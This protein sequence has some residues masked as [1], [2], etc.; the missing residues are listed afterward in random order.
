MNIFQLIFNLF[1]KKETTA[2]TVS[3][4]MQTALTEW[5]DLY[6]MGGL[7]TRPEEESKSYSL[8]LPAGIASEFSRLLLSEADVHLMGGARASYLEVPL[9]AFWT[10]FSRQAEAA[11][12]LGSMVFKPYVSGDTI[13]VNLL[14]ADQYVPTA[15]DTTGVVT[16]AVFVDTKQIGRRY[17]TRLEAHTWDANS[18]KYT[19][20]NRAYMAY[21]RDTLGT[22]CSLDAVDGWEGLKAYQELE[23]ITAPLFSV[24]RVP[25]A[26]RVDMD[27]PI[28]VSV[29]ASA[30][31]LIQEANQMWDKIWWEYCGTELA[32]DVSQDLLEKTK[33]DE[34]RAFKWKL[35]KGGKRLFRGY[36]MAYDSDISKKMQV[37]SPAIR[38]SSLFNGLN[39]ILQRIEFNVGLA[40]GTISEPQDIEKTAEEIR[41][42]KQR[43]YTH[44]SRMQQALETAL[45]GLVYSMGVYADLYDLAPAG[46]VSL[47]CTWGDSVLEDADKEFQRQMQMVSARV[48][49]P[50]KFL[51]WYFGIDESE[52]QSYL[53]DTSDSGGLFSGM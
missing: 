26:N 35:P 52:A 32:L 27:S 13:S 24:F 12:A 36:D 23:N 50:E 29:Y 34:K 40:Y 21:D 6:Q 25:S 3:A 28:G 17:Y 30:V 47:A 37:F 49:K 33:V 45:E 20:E 51:A 11:C 41:S 15:F 43:S 14:R 8:R 42:S 22:P 9:H 5:R 53:P 31:D 7:P 44:V 46:E 48:L 16:A 1:R 4:Q 39:H 2:Y 18:Q 10:Q 19:V 38:D